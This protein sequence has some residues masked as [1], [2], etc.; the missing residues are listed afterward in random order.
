MTRRPAKI[1]LPRWSL[2]DARVHS[3]HGAARMLADE[4]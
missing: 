4:R 1:L 2:V 3:G